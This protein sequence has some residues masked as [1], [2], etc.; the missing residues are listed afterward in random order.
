MVIRNNKL[1]KKVDLKPIEKVILFTFVAQLFLLPE[2]IREVMIQNFGWGNIYP[3]RFYTMG[4]PALYFI[5]QHYMRKQRLRAPHLGI[6][7]LLFVGFIL[8]EFLPS[9]ESTAAYSFV[10]M[11]PF[12]SLFFPA[13]GE[14][15]SSFAL[16]QFYNYVCFLILVSS[17][18]SRVT[19]YK[20]I[21]YA[22]YSGLITCILT[23]MGFLGFINIGEST[24][25]FQESGLTE[26]P[27]TIMS[28]NLIPYIGA[29]TILMLIIKQMNEKKLSVFYVF[30]DI[31]T[32]SFIFI[33]ILTTARRMP[34]IISLIL[35]L[36]YCKLPYQ[37][38]TKLIKL[39]ILFVASIVFVTTVIK[40]V[41][42]DFLSGGPFRETVL[43]QRS[44]ELD[45]TTT[46]I[47][48]RTV[49]LKNAL[50]NFINHPFMGVGYQNVSITDKSTNAIATR[51]GTQPVLILGSCGI[52]YFIFYLYYNFR[53]LV[54]RKYL[55]RRPEVTLSLIFQVLTLLVIRPTSIALISIS[56]YIALY[57]YYESRRGISNLDTPARPTRPT[58]SG[59]ARILAGT[60][61][62]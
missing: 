10:D 27:G 30:R 41:Q 4:L 32:I 5:H 33:M 38:S 24:Y 55:L 17:G 37:F 6:F 59:R 62:K 43:Y 18:L 61:K 21:D 3:L 9:R 56:G 46:G 25:R 50:E 40:I 7:I 15:K 28:L 16:T 13:R 1:S 20:V 23:F 48:L 47:T 45:K 22:F 44:F 36:Y 29:F 49:N 42:T 52:F 58:A 39:L 31:F 2:Y 34:F 8:M 12:R 11:I 54:F 51:T 57:F 60:G 14:V 35:I 26:V 19:F 53:F